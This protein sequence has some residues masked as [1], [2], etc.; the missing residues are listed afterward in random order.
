LTALWVAHSMEHSRDSPMQTVGHAFSYLLLG[1]S[2]TWW[3][4][5]H[6]RHHLSTNEVDNDGDIQLQPFIFLYTPSKK[7]TFGTDHSNMFISHC[8]T[9]CYMLNGSSI[10]YI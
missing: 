2:P 9:A 10:R 1:Y 4:A 5:K 8:Y 7:M 3:S 6:T